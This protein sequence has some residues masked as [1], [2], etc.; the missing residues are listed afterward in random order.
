MKRR[1]KKPKVQKEKEQNN[2]YFALY[3]LAQRE[4]EKKQKSIVHYR[5]LIEYN[6]FFMKKIRRL[7][8]CFLIKKYIR[9]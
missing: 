1:K 4:G 3:I 9:I 7:F 5:V 8:R 2:T 6:E